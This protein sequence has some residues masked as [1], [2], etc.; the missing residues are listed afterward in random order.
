M[1]RQSI[2]VVQV[3][4][5]A[6]AAALVAD[7]IAQLAL[8]QRR[9]GSALVLGLA[10]GRTTTAV[11]EALAERVLARSL[12]LEGAIAFNLDEYCGLSA[13][14]PRS[15]AAWMRERFFD[16]VGWPGE[17]TRIPSGLAG[18]D[19]ER[20]CA[21]YE[22]SIRAAGGL[23]LQLLGIGRNGHIGFNEPGSARD[24][25]TR[26]V[27]LGPETI[28]DAARDFGSAE[29][30]PRFAITIGV[31]TILDAR[32]VRLLAFG[33]KKRAALERALHGEIS[34]DCPASFLRE[35]ADLRVY[36]DAAALGQ[37]LP[38]KAS[39]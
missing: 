31:A 7:E 14:D 29:A 38:R 10:T 36:A 28:E 35:H 9:G 33:E 27:R 21:D 22:A 39:V 20:H 16:R 30:V 19:C 34:S 24:S 23:D 13:S 6:A 18:E 12:E 2:S 1:P 4:D 8:A 37:S 17:R 32:R 5:P 11:Y 26:R 25:R 15:F 3:A